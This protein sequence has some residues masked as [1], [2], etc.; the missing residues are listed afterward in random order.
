MND[1]RMEDL[2][3]LKLELKHKQTTT[4]PLCNMHYGP[5][6]ERK[7]AADGSGEHFYMVFSKLGSGFLYL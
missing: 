1:V 4:R 3:F 6:S 5:I 7:T 2:I